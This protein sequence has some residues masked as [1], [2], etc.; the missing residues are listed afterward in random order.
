[1]SPSNHCTI[2]QSIQKAVDS[3]AEKG[4]SVKVELDYFSID[5]KW[6]VVITA[7]PKQDKG[8]AQT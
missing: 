3:A 7:T 2:M 8:S 1:M 5:G 4:V 6:H